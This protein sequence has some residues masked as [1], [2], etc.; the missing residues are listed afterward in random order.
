MQ[1]A[2][3]FLDVNLDGESSMNH[4]T[5]IDTRCYN[6]Q[7]LQLRAILKHT[8]DAFDLFR[9]LGANLRVQGEGDWVS[10]RCDGETAY[11]KIVW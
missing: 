9:K 7:V 3:E 4:A 2:H 6:Y 5:Q 1:A 10:V 8:A 11:R